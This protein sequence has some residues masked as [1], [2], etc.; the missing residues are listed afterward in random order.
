MMMMMEGGKDGRINE[1]M[2]NER[3]ENELMIGWM[4]G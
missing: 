3:L 2:M 4:Y 1:L